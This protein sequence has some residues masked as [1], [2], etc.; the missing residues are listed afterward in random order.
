MLIECPAL[1]WQPAMELAGVNALVDVCA[2]ESF[3]KKAAAM[4]AKYHLPEFTGKS[5]WAI[6]PDVVA[7]HPSNRNGVRM[8]GQGCE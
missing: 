8:N 6:T 5:E 3:V 2:P 1:R 7:S 4:R